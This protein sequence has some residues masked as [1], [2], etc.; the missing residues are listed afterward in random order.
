M[1]FV[2]VISHITFRSVD[3]AFLDSYF[4]VEANG[5][6]FSVTFG[7]VL[8]WVGRLVLPA[9]RG[10]VLFGEWGGAVAELL[11]GDVNVALDVDLGGWSVTGWVLAVVDAILDVNLGVGVALEGLTVAM[12]S[13]MLVPARAKCV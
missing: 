9:T 2:V 7:R 13:K 5:L 4:L 11:L 3:G 1:A 10:T 12:Q 6:T 8:T